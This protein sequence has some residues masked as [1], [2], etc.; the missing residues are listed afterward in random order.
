[1]NKAY[2]F[3]NFIR[4]YKK[5]FFKVIFYEIFYSLKFREFIPNM[6]IQNNKIR[7][8]TVPC[9]YFFLK[10]ISNFIKKNKINSIV[11]IG[12]GFGRVVRFINKI[13]KIKTFGIEYDVE[14]FKESL[15]FK[16]K[17]I[18]LYCGDIFKFDLKKFSS[19][20]F[21][22]VG[23]FKR[24]QDYKK[25][26][27]KLE[28]IKTKKDKFVVTVNLNKNQIPYKWKLIHIIIGSKKRSLKIYK[29]NYKV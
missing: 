8:D 13:N 17:N 20:C 26:F 29:Y 21:I 7:T 18:K 6:K 1:M 5:I 16:K 27:K 3:L 14:V 28:K 19:N 10:E 23:P 12:S 24:N 22:L 9:V 2:Y 25:F 15:R 11:D 4:S